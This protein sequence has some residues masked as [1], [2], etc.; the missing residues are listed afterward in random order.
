MTFT[1]T[2]QQ[3]YDLV[4]SEAMRA[5]STHIGI[6]DV[7]IAKHCRKSD[8][9]VPERGYWN[10]LQAGQS[11]AK[12]VLPLADLSTPSHVT[13]S[14]E[15]P[16]ELRARLQGEPGLPNQ[17]IEEIDIL[18]E[19][20][21]KRLGAVK[22]PRNFSFTYPAI[23]TLLRKDEK[24]RQEKAA[25]PYYW[26]VPSFD[27]PFERRRL[28]VL[29]GLFL[30]VVK[31]G[32]EGWTRG[33]TARELGVRIGDRHI[34]FEIDHFDGK[35]NRNAKPP[36]DKSAKLSLRIEANRFTTGAET[37][38]EDRDGCPLEE[39]LADIVVGLAKAGAYTHRAILAENDAWQRK[40]KERQE[41]EARQ[42]KEQEEQRERDR[43]AAAEKEKLT[44]LMQQA[45][46]W[47][48]AAEIRAFVAAVGA[49]KDQTDEANLQE[50]SQ[51]ALL[52][53]DKLDPLSSGARLAKGHLANH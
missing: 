51:W 43:L 52:E 18:A 28:Q 30:G 40:E 23:A 27:S 48:K 39:Q 21:R 14:G 33:S 24:H 17:E 35:R 8:I 50:W 12:T 13:M 45:E 6:S 11:V 36:T 19:R 53:A 37:N 7:A 5:L 41:L 16:E 49:M 20:L 32:G 10:K 3:L 2:R 44:A 15:L 25:Q 1:L 29:N 46:D 42:R 47:R 22:C 4:W 31:I 9:P 26:Q 38:W 34:S